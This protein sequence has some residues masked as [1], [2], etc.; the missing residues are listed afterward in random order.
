MKTN[1][2][3]AV[4]S[5]APCGGGK[6]LAS[7]ETEGD[8][9]QSTGSERAS[10][11]N[12]PSSRRLACGARVARRDDHLVAV[13]VHGLR[14]HGVRL[15]GL[16]GLFFPSRVLPAVRS[17]CEK[18]RGNALKNVLAQASCWGYLRSENSDAMHAN[19]RRAKWDLLLITNGVAS[20]CV[21]LV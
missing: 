3:Y 4:Y 2:A 11:C 1:L 10:H 7:S 12:C 5:A 15:P 21:L 19:A 8:R 6:H 14:G 9:Q 18:R 13:D 20:E 16:P 17:R